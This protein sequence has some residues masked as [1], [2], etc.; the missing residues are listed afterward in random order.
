[1]RLLEL[2]NVSKSYGDTLAVGPVSFALEEGEFL[3]LLGPSGCGKTT[4][5][6]CIAGLERPTEGEILL[7]GRPI[8][9]SPPHLRE[10]GLVFQ[11]Y[12]LFPH[13]TVFE[14]VAFGLRLRHRPPAEIAERVEGCMRLVDMLGLEVRYPG[15]LSGG[16]QQRVAL[17]RSLAL[18]PRILLLDEPLSNL[19]FKLRLQMRGEL[20]RLQERLH[21]ATIY[22][23]HDQGEALALS[24]RI[25]ILCHG[26]VEQVGTPREIY[27]AP[28]TP[29]VADFIGASNLVKA[30]IGPATSEGTLG[31]WV[32]GVCL[33]STDKLPPSTQPGGEVMVLLRPHRIS[34]LHQGEAL[35]ITDNV[36]PA[37]VTDVTFLGEDLQIGC[38]LDGGPTLTANIK[39]ALAETALT[40]GDRILACISARDVRL[41]PGDEG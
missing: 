16:Q 36:L 18:Q 4:T 14:N 20:K 28:R 31:V 27:E 10:I 12:A 11:N 24:D 39:A 19:D 25:V 35:P 15:Q 41:L 26:R 37:T 30:R 29:F 17:A 38:E 23:T 2:R 32:A 1:M 9:D 7:D 5:L 6:R 8:T 13:L 21:K 22:V 40:V 33:K 34:I 3:S